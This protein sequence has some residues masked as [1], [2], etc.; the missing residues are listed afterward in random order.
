MNAKAILFDFDGTLADTAADLAR[1]LNHLRAA[2]GL[3]ELP[4]ESLR[5]FASA[6]ARGLIGAGLGIPPEHP[7]FNALRESFLSHYAAEICVDTRLFPGMEELLAAIEARGTRWGIVTNKST[8][9]TRLLVK[10]LGLETR[11]ACV[12]CGDTTPHLKPHPASLLHAAKEIALAPQDCIYLGDDLRDVQAARAAGM[13]S[14]A[15]EW[16]YG[17]GLAAWQADAIIAR[18]MDLI[19]SL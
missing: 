6:G 7:E 12:V 2:R 5:P 11:A 15:V 9:L 1:P 8:S 16:G 19:A 3:P 18:P 17:E 4:L 13:R 14:V 10:K